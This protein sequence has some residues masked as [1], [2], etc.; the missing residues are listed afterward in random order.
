MK[1]MKTF[2]ALLC[3]LN[4]N[5]MAQDDQTNIN[6]GGSAELG[7]RSDFYFRGDAKSAE[8]LTLGVG[9]TTSVQGIS[10]FANHLSNQPEAGGD[11]S[12]TTVGAGASF[13]DSL[14]S[15]YGGVLNYDSDT[16]GGELDLFINTQL[17]TAINLQ[18]TLYRNT[19][20]DLY[21]FEASAGKDFDL[22]VVELGVSVDGGTTEEVGNTRTYYGATVTA[23]KQFGAVEVEVGGSL[24]DSDEI[25]T[26]EVFF[27]GLN[28][29]F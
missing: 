15:V 4:I 13:L 14:V 19:D 1:T 5:A 6:L 16:T 18:G 26:D 7:Y 22:D 25:S 8:S 29:S 10:V 17:N 27:A 24:I 23:S 2:L 21:T 28:F 12:L 3:A 9:V 11:L 20:S